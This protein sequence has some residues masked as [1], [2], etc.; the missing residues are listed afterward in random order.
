[1]LMV[2]YNQVVLL[3]TFK[4]IQW[5]DYSLY[6]FY[7]IPV[8]LGKNKNIPVNIFYYTCSPNF[9]KWHLGPNVWCDKITRGLGCCF[10]HQEGKDSCKILG[11]FAHVPYNFPIMSKNL[12]SWILFDMS[13]LLMSIMSFSWMLT[14]SSPK[15]KSIIL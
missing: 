10:L 12:L 8:N 13:E 11:N 4:F 9:K 5:N 6:L 1:M 2:L 7:Y 15:K 3:A 14:V